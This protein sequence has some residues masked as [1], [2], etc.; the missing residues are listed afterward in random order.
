MNQIEI[1]KFTAK[2][3]DWLLKQHKVHYAREEGF[4][5]SFGVLVGT[6]LDDFLATHDPK[7]EAGWIAWQG[8]QRLGS[9]FCVKLNETTA[10]L[11]LFL[12]VPEAR[13]TGLGRRMLNTCTGFARDHGYKQMQLWTHESHRAAGA[14]YARAGWELGETKQVISFGKENVEQTWRITL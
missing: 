3:R 8:D 2:D 12:L 6:I 1:R 11:R 5:D 10:K 9:V 7:R 14:L 13:G 4:D